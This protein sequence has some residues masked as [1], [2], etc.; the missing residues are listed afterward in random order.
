MKTFQDLSF[1]DY[2][3][4][5]RRRIW[6]VI[7]PA[8]LISASSAVYLRRLPSMYKS[9]TTIMGTSRLLPEDYIAS[10]VR[11]SVTDRIDFVR[12]QLR[13]R[14]FVEGIIQEFQLAKTWTGTMEDLINNFQVNLEIATVSPGTF[15]VAYTATSPARAQAITRRL[16]ERVLTLNDTVRKD[17]V[18]A[19]DHFLDEEVRRAAGELSVAENKVRQF[20]RLHFPGIPDDQIVSLGTV[21]GFERQ[22][23]AM[24]SDLENKVSQRRF[25]ARRLD[26]QRQLT[27][28]LQNPSGPS[29]SPQQGPQPQTDNQYAQ[30]D[31]EKA[32][33][34]KQSELSAAVSRYT[35]LHPDVVRLSRQVR[36]LQEQVA[37][38]A[39]PAKPPTS[40]RA[41]EA[42]GPVVPAA[43]DRSDDLMQAEI[44]LELE[45]MDRQIAKQEQAKNDL[46]AKISLYRGRLNLPAALD[47]QLSAL[48]REVDSAKQRLNLLTSKKLSSDMA[49]SVD[50][51]ANNALFRI[52]DPANLPNYPISPD[53]P[54]LLAVGCLLGLGIGLGIAFLR[55]FADST[56]ADEDEVSS[57][58]KLP[59]LAS[60]PIVPSSQPKKR[61]TSSKRMLSLIPSPIETCEPASFSLHAADSK[62][63]QVIFGPVSIAGEQYRVVHASLAL[64]R[65]Q[66]GLKS[67]LIASTIP[68]EGKSFVAAC[69]AGVLAREAGNSVL[70]IHADMRTSKGLQMLGLNHRDSSPIG[71]SEVLQGSANVNEAILKSTE[72]NLY[73]LP[74]GK[75]VSNP[76][77]LLCTPQFENLLRDIG[78][79]FHW[80]IIDSPPI[81]AL[82]DARLLVPLCDAALLVVR[83]DKTPANLVKDCIDRV[84]KDHICGV[85]LNGARNIKSSHYYEPYYHRS[86]Q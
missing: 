65:K 71:L 83:A 51:S 70:L 24:T 28:L 55:E 73:L 9:E 82:A 37:A 18:Y 57:R 84:G 86:S 41:A 54:K 60:I 49:G 27:A 44:Q 52:L 67:I 40:S 39:R 21:D 7:V 81:L 15:R 59:V 2:F 16:A 47:Q 75:I 78:P 1:T 31:L 43:G 42:S 33:A 36:E 19:A 48:T 61:S 85:L 14:T 68:N 72:L 25:L 13:S 3:K 20:N 38:Q 26:E 11:E 12:Q 4:I 29:R 79:S 69:L 53:R 30:T 5:I 22:L 63:K 45:Q 17:K 23:V 6:W 74:S 50:T 77:E 66:H 10:L 58:L 64:K 56:L 46:A 62:V 34:A 8:F 32:L 35:P 80:I 76:I